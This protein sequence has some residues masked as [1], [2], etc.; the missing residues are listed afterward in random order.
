MTRYLL[1]P[2]GALL[3][4]VS[5]AGGAQAQQQTCQQVLQS[6]LRRIVDAFGQEIIYYR[7]PVRF[8]CSDGIQIEADSA[9]MNSS[10][11]TVEL[12]GH[13]LYRDGDRQLTADWATY[14]SITDE[15]FAR[16]GVVLTD[17]AD[18]SVISGD[19]FEYHRQTE[20]RLESRMIMRGQRPHAV[21][22]PEQAPGA[23]EPASPV[24]VWAQRM[25][26]LGETVFLAQTDV[27]IQRSDMQGAAD[28][29]RF[30]QAA[31]RMTLTGSAHVES[32][33]YR[34]EGERIDALMEN[35]VLQEVRAE[36]RGRLVAAELTVRGEQIRIAF[37]DG[38]PERIEAWNPAARRAAADEED[39]ED[40]EDETMAPRALAISQ[41]FRLRADSIDA[42]SEGGRLRQVTAVGR[43]YGEGVADTLVN[44]LPD[45]I[46]RDWIQGD[47]IIGY[48]VH[49]AGNDTA[50]TADGPV[51]ADPV[52]I[53]VDIDIDTLD[54]V[55]APGMVASEADGAGAD[56]AVLERIEVVGGDSHALS[57]Y[58]TEP[59]DG[60]ARPSV[61]FMR[62][63]RITLFM[64]NGEVD[65]VEAD[66]P[67]EGI[68]L[69]P[70]DAARPATRIAS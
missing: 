62:A 43:A 60:G 32:D 10:A 40:A 26:M 18:G 5:L 37:A 58:R 29:V 16:G 38:Q 59:S 68:Y 35:D 39:R 45:V 11:N 54:V 3:A 27:E 51:V 65:R 14:L 70:D 63:K 48:F 61:N 19:D 13:V 67:I 47:T 7:N 52:D 21:L 44:D 15:L 28:T 41:D 36:R 64:I 22:R 56:G 17:M 57:L 4:L 69:D 46:S 30:D 49:Q 2:L 1:V 6:D 25:E 53:D 20:E 66:G 24:L 34:L 50:P 9:V 33:D 23:V 55:G 8:L 12:V 42:R 31:E